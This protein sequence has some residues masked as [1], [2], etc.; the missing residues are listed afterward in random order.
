M[1]NI[2][3]KKETIGLPEQIQELM[4]QLSEYIQKQGV[5][6]EGKL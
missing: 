4:R 6:N 1:S 3:K 5:N 2:I